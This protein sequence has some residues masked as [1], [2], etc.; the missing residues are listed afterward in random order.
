M[1]VGNEQLIDEIIFL[2]R[3][4]LLATPAAPLCPVIGE[5]LRF[6][7]AGMRERHHHV[8]WGDEILDAQIVGIDHHFGT[9]LVAKLGANRRQ[10][11]G[12][13]FVDAFGPRQ[14]VHEIGNLFQQFGIIGNDLVAFQAG[15]ALQ[16]QFEDRLC[17][18][19]GKQ[20]TTLRQ[21]ILQRQP[22]RAGG[23]K[24][25][26]S[27]HL[28]DCRRRPEFA[29]QPAPCV[30]GSRRGLDQRDDL[31]D[32]IKRHRQ[33]FLNMRPFTRLPEFK[34]GTPGNDFAP[35]R[36][37]IVDQLLEVQETRLP[38]DQRH[39]VHAEGVLQLRHLVEIV[40]HDFRH[41]AALQLDHHA[42]AGFV[43]F[44]AQV[45]NPFD[46]LVVDQFADLFQQGALVHLVGK[47]INDDRLPVIAALDIL[48]MRLG[49]HDHAAPAGV[50]SLPHAGNAVDDAGGR[51]IRCRDN[52]DQ[53]VNAHVRVGQQCQAAVD[54]LVHVVRWDVRRHADSDTGRTIDQQV[55]EAGRQHQWLT[56]GAVV[57]RAEIDGFL[58]D[59]GEHFMADARHAHLGITH[60]RCAVAIDRTEIA[61]S[62]DQHV[63]QRK[64]LRHAHDG[65]VNRQ[66]A[67]RVVLT[68]HVTDDTRALFEG[69]VP[70]VVLFVHGEQHTAMH[71]FQAIPRIRQRSPDDHAHRVIEVGAAHLVFKADGEGFFGKLFGGLFHV[72]SRK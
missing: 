26:T 9:A 7:V 12:N 49:T 29:H 21:P 15:Q 6:D 16:T 27:Q 69:L 57:V 25:G 62:V 35:V 17:L 70:V 47:F 28:G 39:H 8:L 42:H 30:G 14:N 63:A 31:I 2:H 51:E 46:T 40:E 52:A 66:I 22:F 37:E 45:G 44:I 72:L 60:R 3:R 59:V 61:L 58:V 33:T 4:C 53:L 10:F 43:R 56:F 65:V 71:G 1:R 13:D 34:D 64:R 24:C 38:I 5:R 23:V 20:I 36:K 41:F 67:V 50:I 19:F 32:V 48:E 55:R 68:H 54:H 18:R 11:L